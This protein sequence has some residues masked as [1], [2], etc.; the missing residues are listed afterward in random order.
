MDKLVCDQ[1]KLIVN[2]SRPDKPPLEFDIESL[3][4]TTIGPGSPMHFDAKLTNPKPVGQIM[5]S[6]LFGPWQPDS[7]RDTPVSGTYSF[8]HADLGTVKGIGGILS[9]TG[10][11][12]GILDKIVVDGTTDTP[13]FHIAISGR[14][15]PLHTEFHAI[16]DGT[17]GD[18]YLQP[19]R[20]GFWVRGWWR[21][22]RW[23]V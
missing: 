5:S 13:D 1:A 15:V 4:M 21:M 7:P 18:T 2:T 3:K 8:D 22:G 12:A 14:N 23:C 9:S 10:K 6:G 17:N 11:Y 20:A 16:V 19:V